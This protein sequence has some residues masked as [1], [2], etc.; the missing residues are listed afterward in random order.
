MYDCVFMLNMLYECLSDNR[1]I[2]GSIGRLKVRGI[3]QNRCIYIWNFTK[4][5]KD[6]C[7]FILYTHSLKKFVYTIS[8]SVGWHIII[9]SF[10]VGRFVGNFCCCWY[11]YFCSYVMWICGACVRLSLT[12]SLAVYYENAIS[13]GCNPPLFYLIILYRIVTKYASPADNR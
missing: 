3:P 12:A 9:A 8:L 4:C 7:T 1:W 13:S 6:C 10:W 2:V 5:W 11:F